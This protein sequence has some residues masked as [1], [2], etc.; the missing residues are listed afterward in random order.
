MMRLFIL[1]LA[2]CAF[3]TSANAAPAQRV[4]ALGGDVT[5]IVYGLGEGSRVVCA[6]ETSLYP[7][8]VAKLPKVGY[9][10]MLSAEGVLS[11]KPDL[12]IASEDAGPPAAMTQL[13]NSG[14]TIL[15]AA[16]ARAPDAV[17]EKIAK[18]ADA[19]GV[20][21]KGRALQEK[22]RADLAAA[23]AR[24]EKLKDRP[25]ALFLMSQGPGG[26]MAA[27][28]ETAADAMFTLAR[29]ENV[30][31]GYTHYKPLTPE[32]AV[33]FKPDVI[34][35]ADNAVAMMGGL[36]AIR[37]RPEIAMTP[38]GKNGRVVTMDIMLLLGFGPR[39]PE[40]LAKL[41]DSL[42]SGAAAKPTH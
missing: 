36:E 13:A 9:L 27:G 12:I 5:E 24:I 8:A 4:V 25:R 31:S 29:S 16:N 2:S 19:L 14:V 38:A 32:A 21:A 18:I 35:V 41:A 23:Q 39:T 1:A 30:A 28:R 26:L 22:F 10:R 37:A 11:C 33:G 34:V 17:P 3:A 40:A 42:H 20:G 7:P 6:D 15:H